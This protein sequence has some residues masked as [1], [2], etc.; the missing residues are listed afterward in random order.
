[1]CVGVDTVIH[2]AW[3]AE[4]GKYLSSPKNMLCLTGTLSLAEAA[5]ASSVKRFVGVGKCFEY[6]LDYPELATSTPLAPKTSYASA[7]AAA[8]YGLNSWL[9]SQGVEFAWCRLF[10]LYGEAE[11]TRRL[12]PYLHAQL[13]SGAKVELTKGTQIRD[14]M[15][16]ETA[17]KMIAELALTNK[18]G[19]YNICSGIPVSIRQLAEEIADKYGRRDLLLF[20]ARAENEVD[21]ACVVGVP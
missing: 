8:Y 13:K 21:P 10:Y 19:A 11:D 9:P 16:V 12:V 7:K 3:Y 14:F 20:G 1:M 4:P 6:D 2:V 15:D 5:A 18:Q 17:G